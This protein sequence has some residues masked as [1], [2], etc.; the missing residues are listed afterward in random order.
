VRKPII[1]ETLIV[2]WQRIVDITARIA[3]VPSSLVMRTEP[4]DHSVLVASNT[5]D[6]PYQ[7][8]MSFELNNKLYCYS[9]LQK[10]D[11]LVVRNAHAESDWCDNQDLEHGMSFYIGY[12][13]VWP[14]GTL[15]GTICVL[16][17]RENQKAILHRDLLLEFCRLIKRDLALL[18]EVA[19][20]QRLEGKLQ[21]NLRELE[22]RV[23]E[24]TR[25]LTEVNL[26][27]REEVS[28]RKK[29]KRRCCNVSN[30]LRKPIQLSACFSRK[31]S[32]LALRSRSKS[33]GR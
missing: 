12:P 7:V 27:L 26:G 1:P 3:D 19:E 23:A 17:R 25:E 6:N 24:R 11:E 29:Q 16:D 21:D 5:N 20:R 15:F 13:L 9:V 22:T 14:D 8:G 4:P 31:S 2:D 28:C 18:S 10:R 32:H 33:C 30:S